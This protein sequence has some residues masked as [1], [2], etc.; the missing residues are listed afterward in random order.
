MKTKVLIVISNM[1]FGGAQ[2][3]IVELINNMDQT[4]FEVHLC[5]LSEYMPLADQ[6]DKNIPVHIIHKKY[7][8]DFSVVLRITKLIR[9]HK[10]NIIHSYLFDAEIAVRLAAKLSITN[11]K[12]VGSERNTNYTLKPIQKKAYK[13]TKHLV[14]NIIANSQSGANFNAKLTG[15]PVNK[16]HVVYNGVNTQKFK[17]QDSDKVRSEL[18]VDLNVKLIGMFASFK[19]Q[20]NHPFL[21]EA[22][23]RIKEDGYN[24]K[25][26]LVGD[27]LHGGLHGSDNYASELKKKIAESNIA[28]DVIYLGNRNDIERIYPICDFTVLPSLFEGTPNVILESMACGVPVIATDISDNKII[29]DHERN[30][31]IVPLND[32]I[33]LQKKIIILLNDNIM[34]KSMGKAAKQK[35]ILNYSSIR[36]AENTQKIYEKLN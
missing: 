22:L 31:F 3:Q 26:L 32:S 20:K 19:Q 11:I 15:Q 4:K 28:N 8:F 16:Y 17:E 7:K 34:L 10:F 5:S 25:L 35:V 14:G 23:K 27:E 29:I 33:E 9:K 2:R 6:L 36:L 24:F 13:L 30:G 21:I 18:G 12:V 1:E